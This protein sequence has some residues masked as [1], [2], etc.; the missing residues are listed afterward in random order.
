[1]I[2]VLFVVL[3]VLSGSFYY[4]ARNIAVRSNRGRAKY[5]GAVDE[6]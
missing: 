2:G 6:K 1:M 5:C 4:L 3:T